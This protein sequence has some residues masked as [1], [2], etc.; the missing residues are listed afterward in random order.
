MRDEGVVV[1]ENGVLGM[2]VTFNKRYITLAPVATVI[3]LAFKLKDPNKLLK[4]G[5]EGITVALLPTEANPIC[6]N[7]V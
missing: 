2:R 5:K 6:P 7:G 3:G 4:T 1:V